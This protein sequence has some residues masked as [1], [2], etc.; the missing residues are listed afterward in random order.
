MT[1]QEVCSIMVSA[2]DLGE[3]ILAVHAAAE[4]P[5]F[6]SARRFRYGNVVGIGRPSM[7]DL[8]IE[9]VRTGHHAGHPIAA[10]RVVTHHRISV[11][12]VFELNGTRA[13]AQFHCATTGSAELTDTATSWAEF[14]AATTS[15]ALTAADVAA[16]LRR[17]DANSAE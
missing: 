13:S 2:S 17:R 10:L 15:A 1:R 16:R 14:L 12:V 3:L 7:R 8:A 9:T 11:D 5:G 6:G 4:Q